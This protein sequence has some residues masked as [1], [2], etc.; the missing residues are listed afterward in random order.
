MTTGNVVDG[1]L[2]TGYTETDQ[3]KKSS[4]S[5]LGKDAFLQLLV[6]QMK[7]QDPLNP[8]DSS[9]MVSQLA[10]FSALEEM[11]NVTSAVTNSQALSLVGKNV[12]VEV[13][14]STGSSNTVKVGGYVQYVQMVSG[15]AKLC[16]NGTLY[17]YEDLD[18]VVDDEY[19]KELLESGQVED[20]DKENSENSENQD[21]SE[22][23]E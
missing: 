15:D 11:Q 8:S 9:E 21:D 1:E 22:I 2:Q 16:I 6:T 20:S 10:Q 17:D 3:S 5:E 23:E 7:Y 14:K 13:G 12:I 18:M 4:G 19:L